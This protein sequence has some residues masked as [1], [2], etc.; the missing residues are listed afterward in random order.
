M[1]LYL[2]ICPGESIHILNESN[3]ILVGSP[4]AEPNRKKYDMIL[5]LVLSIPIGFEMTCKPNPK[6]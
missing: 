6:R 1:Y 4:G 2:G 5:N 3:P